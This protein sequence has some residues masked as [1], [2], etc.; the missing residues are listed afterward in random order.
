[1][2]ER[3]G[4][5]LV[6]TAIARW[7]WA[8][9]V[10]ISAFVAHARSLGHGLL[11][12][13]DVPYILEAPHLGLDLE[14]VRWAFGTVHVAYW[15]P[16]TWLSYALDAALYGLDG[17]GFHLTNVLLHA[18][19]AVL[20]GALAARCLR[21]RSGDAAPGWQAADLV[22]AI[23]AGTAWAVHPLRVESVAWVAERKDVLSV[24]FF[25]VSL[26]AWLHWVPSAC[27][28]RRGRMAWYVAAL[29][30]AALATLAK[31]TAVV[32]PAILLLLDWHPLGRLDRVRAL[33][34]LVAEK[35]PF[36]AVAT[37]GAIITVVAQ[38]PA[39]WSGSIDLTTRAL[40]AAKALVVYLGRTLWPVDLSPFY[41]HPGRVPLGSA[42][43]LA[44]AAAVVAVTVLSWRA[45]RR[46]PGWLAL[47]CGY[48]AAC[49]PVLGIVQVG[50]Q[51]TADR[52][53]Y[54]PGIAPALLCGALA[55]GAWE[56]G[57]GDEPGAA[58][59]R[60]ALVATALALALPLGVLS[61]R[62]TGFW[63]SDVALWTRVL[64]LDPDVGVAYLYRAKALEA[65]LER[66]AAVRDLGAAIAIAERKGYYRAD[67]L[68]LERAA[69]LAVLGR[70]DAA[71][72]DLL[73]VRAHPP[74]FTGLDA[75]REETVRRLRDSPE[76]GPTPRDA[77]LR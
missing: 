61:W 49:V 54:L 53:T 34:R 14:T 65:D 5:S 23:V 1:V 18:V 68:Y 22:A 27:R 55:R 35:L 7:A 48:V 29:A 73:R 67:E 72:R 25:L 28:P 12:W 58:R 6:G 41:V 13:D 47:W 76:C 15:L 26:H 4:A 44:A 37:G 77:S 9:A 75:K 60:P 62:Q 16:L 24:A 30:A 70:C 2:A 51:E 63:V 36:L 64:E 31:G 20:V 38:R 8:P 32:L 46:E 56:R 59:W 42:V 43:Y 11:G 45:R 74:S 19:N 52:H 17:P 40:V 71:G 33:P 66:E 10:A 21:L 57:A 3:I 39:M 69:I 50:L